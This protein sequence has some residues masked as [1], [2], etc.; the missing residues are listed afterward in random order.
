MKKTKIKNK[1]ERKAGKDSNQSKHL[2]ITKFKC[3]DLKA[4][5]MLGLIRCFFFV[6]GKYRKFV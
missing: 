2:D 3:I 5:K 1:K 6:F 4:C